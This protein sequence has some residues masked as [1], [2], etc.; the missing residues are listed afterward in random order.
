MILVRCKSL[1]LTIFLL[2]TAIVA[3]ATPYTDIFVFG[4]SLSDNGNL[5]LVVGHTTPTPISGNDFIP[6][7]PYDRGP[8]LL[9]AL[10]N[11]ETWVEQ[12]ADKLGLSLTPSLLGGNDYAFA[13]ARMAPN[14]SSPIPSV[15]E[16]VDT[17]LTSID[18][19][20]GQDA[21]AD[22]LYSVW[23]GGNDARDAAEAV[24]T[25]G[26]PNAAFPFIT[27]YVESLSTSIQALAAEGAKNILVPNIPD[28]GKTPAILA[29]G[30]QASAAVSTMTAGFNASA[31]TM[32]ANLQNS[33]DIN[34]MDFD[35]FSLINKTVT[36]PAINGF[37]DISNACAVNPNCM[38]NAD[39]SFFWDGI[40]PTTAGHAAIAQAVPLQPL[41]EPASMLLILPGLAFTM[42]MRN[43]FRH[44]A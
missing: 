33:L 8:D 6:S 43:R 32:L 7:L 42:I 40:H 39:T 20:T 22:A 34:L 16:Q 31:Q 30:P 10:S 26:D 25:S 38:A 4:D 19:S 23:G 14:S 44:Q 15:Q 9:P 2:A 21:P 12:L 1:F 27:A 41:P 3:Q 11:G 29:A 28:I 35:T 37:E 36:Y 24:L 17:Y 5:Y 13:G 18:V